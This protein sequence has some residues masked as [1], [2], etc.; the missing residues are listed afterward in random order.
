MSN[1]LKNSERIAVIDGVRTPFA[2]QM[3]TLKHMTSLDLAQMI[4]NE[5]TS[6]HYGI[7]KYVEQL[8]YGQ[9]IL[10]PNIPNIA[11][12][13]ILGTRLKSQIDAYSISKACVSSLQATINICG[14]IK[15]GEIKSGIAGGGDSASNIPFMSSDKFGKWLLNIIKT[16][17]FLK[18][19][20]L[21]SKFKLKYFLPRTLS[22]SEYTTGLLM[23]QIA[24]QMAQKYGISRADQDEFAMKSH[25][26]ASQAEIDK[27]MRQHISILFLEPYD[28]YITIDNNIRH[29]NEIT[30]YGNLK[31]AFV[32]N[33]GTVTAGNS[34]VMTD[35]AAAILLMSEK[36][37]LE[38]ELEPLGYIRAY[39]NTA[40]SVEEDML[41][42]PSFSIPRLL[43]QE[44][45]SFL[46]ID[47]FDF[48]EAFAAQTLS[49][50]KAL[51][52]RNFLEKNN[53]YNKIGSIDLHKVNPLGG[54]IA[55]GHPF[56]ATGIR[57]ILQN[58]IQLKKTNK[59]L[60]I[61]ASCA[62]GG[63]GCSILLEVNSE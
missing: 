46:D 37:A 25:I 50:I 26:N 39:N 47:L 55:Y 9:V 24:E 14:S 7:E 35:G 23:G 56:A 18:K 13:V 62:A 1:V 38:L 3:T 43:E 49:N 44:K 6:R 63:F 19:I 17:S 21:L 61:I 16:K 60:G 54:S 22:P 30:K 2:K 15:S 34:S 51:N 33:I 10:N 45:M 52:S 53:L 27:V 31:P 4:V 40:I 28:N 41:M 29:D 11:R 8:V 57:L 12:E 58:L 48:H 5:L 42:G 20:K 32:Q 59:N 36:K